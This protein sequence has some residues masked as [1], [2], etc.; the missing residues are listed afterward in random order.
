M[1]RVRA[2]WA[3][4]M[5]DLSACAAPS[6]TAPCTCNEIRRAVMIWG[7]TGAED[8]KVTP[9][10]SHISHILVYERKHDCVMPSGEAGHDLHTP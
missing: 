4:R 7:T 6:A 8:A 3:S 10:Q 9:T 1:E 2:R 5:E